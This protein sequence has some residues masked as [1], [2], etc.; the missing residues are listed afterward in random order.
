MQLSRNVCIEGTISKNTEIEILPYKFEKRKNKKL[1]Y[2]A[3]VR[4]LLE[5]VTPL[6]GQSGQRSLPGSILAND[7]KLGGNPW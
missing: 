6:N 2:F 4:Q 3:H 7:S 5:T 1:T